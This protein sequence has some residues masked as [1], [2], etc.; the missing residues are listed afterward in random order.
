MQNKRL[1]RGTFGRFLVIAVFLTSCGHSVVRYKDGPEIMSPPSNSIKFDYFVGGLFPSEIAVNASA[2]CRKP[3]DL[4][5]TAFH[6]SASD[7]LL[8][9]IT[10]NI[11]S[12]K[13]LD[14]WCKQ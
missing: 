14:V 1:N 12:P 11:Y 9:A 2:L 3:S 13:T 4:Q 10:L 8:T 5:Q 6:Y 7:A